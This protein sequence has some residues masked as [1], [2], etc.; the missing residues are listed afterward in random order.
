M[1]PVF[2]CPVAPTPAVLPASTRA[3]YLLTP[4]ASSIVIRWRTATAAPSVI[5]YGK[6]ASNLNMT[7]SQ[8]AA[9]VIEHMVTV[10][11]LNPGTLYYYAAGAAAA[12]NT[13]TTMFFKTAPAAGSYTP[14][15][16]WIMGDFGAR[17]T[18]PPGRRHACC[19]EW[20]LPWMPFVLDAAARP[21][22][23]SAY[24]PRY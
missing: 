13:T 11:G 4:T 5:S 8:D 3:P 7:V 16:S 15:R 12:S 10:T 18:S 6:N 1:Y 19:V 14:F 20:C 2:N 23:A 21:A 17:R 24:F 9:G 22:N